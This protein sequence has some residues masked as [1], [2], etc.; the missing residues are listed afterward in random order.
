MSLPICEHIK[1]GGTRC[2]SPSVRGEKYCHYHA[3]AHRLIPPTNLFV[4][5]C[6]PG[7]EKDPCC[8]YE[9]PQLEDGAAIQVGFMQL[10]H[11]VAQQRVNDRRAKLILSA[12]HGAAANLRQMNAALA[13]AEKP[14]EA[15]LERGA[16]SEDCCE[17]SGER[18]NRSADPAQVASEQQKPVPKK[19]AESARISENKKEGIA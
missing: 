9:F 19:S 6:N 8:Q 7:H 10:I 1:P 2:G 11:A 16:Q 14:A 18:R 15:S 13:P 4:L 3:G 17:A 12:L 5:L